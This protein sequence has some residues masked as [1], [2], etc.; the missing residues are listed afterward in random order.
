MIY[1]NHREYQERRIYSSPKRAWIEFKIAK[2]ECN[3]DKIKYYP[4]GTQKF[5]R[6]LSLPFSNFS[7]ILMENGLHNAK[8]K[9]EDSATTD[10]P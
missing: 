1:C 7:D 6:Q 2:K 5:E 3:Q 4:E 8:Q 9:E 10:E